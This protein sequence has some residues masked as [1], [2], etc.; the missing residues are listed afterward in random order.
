MNVTFLSI[1]FNQL[2]PGQIIIAINL[3][4][5]TRTHS[6][7]LIMQKCLKVVHIC[8]LWKENYV[9]SK[10]RWNSTFFKDQSQMCTHTSCMYL[11][12]RNLWDLGFL[13]F[14]W[15]G[16]RAII[17]ERWRNGIIV[18]TNEVY[19]SRMSRIHL[20]PVIPRFHCRLCRRYFADTSVVISKR[21]PTFS[22]QKSNGICLEML[23]IRDKYRCILKQAKR[24]A[25]VGGV[26][27]YNFRKCKQISGHDI[28]LRNSSLS[29]VNEAC[30]WIN[31]SQSTQFIQRGELCCLRPRCL[32]SKAFLS[33]LSWKVT[34]TRSEQVW[35]KIL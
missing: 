24:R 16:M 3:L 17:G 29:N 18:N 12:L 34:K 15:P 30:N 14:V 5:T 23:T 2:K 6:L 7:K 27:K 8:T 25:Y 9:W 31:T 33:L 1:F 32:F 21:W 20:P 22:N 13:H 4:T 10:T 19:L 28:S 35:G 26:L 11:S